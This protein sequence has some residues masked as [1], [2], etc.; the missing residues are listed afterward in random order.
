MMCRKIYAVWKEWVNV[1]ENLDSELD[2]FEKS[3]QKIKAEKNCKKTAE[4]IKCRE[5]V[6][7]LEFL[8]NGIDAKRSKSILARSNR[9]SIKKCQNIGY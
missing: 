1:L 2:N 4:T 5:L 8:S 9:R 3:L 7:C 6:Q